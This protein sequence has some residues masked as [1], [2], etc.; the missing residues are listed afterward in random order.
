MLSEKK[1]H[2]HISNMQKASDIASQAHVNAMSKS[3]LGDG[4]WN[5]QAIIE[6]HFISNKSRCSY[7]SIVG[8]GSN[9][10]ILHYNSNDSLIND[11]DLVLIDA[12]CE[13]EG[14]A[15][16][17][18]RTWPING[19]FS[20]AQREIYE[21]VLEAELAGI[22]A[23]KVGAPWKSSH[24]AAS[25]VLAK[26]LIELGIIN[27][28]LD[29]AL[30]DNFDGPFRDFFY[31]VLLDKESIFNKNEIIKTLNA[32][33]KG[34]NNSEKIFGLVMFELWRKSYNASL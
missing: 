19:I 25:K 23:C 24:H 4:E 31:D 13:V 32:N 30:G 29:D 21:L 12:G 10:T 27:C 17:I 6:E 28:S 9:A 14:Y 18:T 7:G 33:A 34:R 22:N 20:E 8:S 3:K 15:S 1:A 5:I 11:G 16:D 2:T 26:G